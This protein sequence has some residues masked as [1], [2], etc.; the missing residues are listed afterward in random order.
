MASRSRNEGM[1]TTR[2]E[3]I[4]RLIARNRV[5]IAAALYFIA[6]LVFRLVDP[7]EPQTRRKRTREKQ[8]WLL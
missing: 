8:D 4:V 3:K 5:G 1:N 6:G 2:I 7:D